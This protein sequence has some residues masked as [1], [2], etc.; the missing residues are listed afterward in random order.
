MSSCVGLDGLDGYHKPN[1]RPSLQPERGWRPLLGGG[2]DSYNFCPHDTN[3]CSAP[4]PG[5]GLAREG[6]AEQH[7]NEKEE[8]EDDFADLLTPEQLEADRRDN[9]EE[10]R[11]QARATYF[12]GFILFAWHHCRSFC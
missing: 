10:R 5:L 7:H 3:G 1:A 2:N 6:R 8:E 9:K 12:L 11:R 4:G